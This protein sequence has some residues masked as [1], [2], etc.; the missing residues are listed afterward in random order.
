MQV[1]RGKLP[2][3]KTPFRSKRIRFAFPYSSLEVHRT[4]CRRTNVGDMGRVS[5]KF[6]HHYRMGKKFLRL[7]G[8][9]VT[10][11]TCKVVHEANL[12]LGALRSIP[13]GVVA[14]LVV[15]V[16]PESALH[17]PIPPK[18]S[19]FPYWPAHAG[20]FGLKHFHLGKRWSKVPLGPR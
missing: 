20:S 7:L 8:L 13:K 19:G 9:T 10:C 5:K 14:I 16:R 12:P 3:R 18:D 15:L 11:K 4:W 6:K 1:F 17:F 2:L